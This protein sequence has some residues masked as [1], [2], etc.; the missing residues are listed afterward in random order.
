[1]SGKKLAI[2][3]L[4]SSVVALQ[5]PKYLTF[6]LSKYIKISRVCTRAQFGLSAS[7]HHHSQNRDSLK[8][9][10]GASAGLLSDGTREY[11]FID[12]A[13]TSALADCSKLR[14]IHLWRILEHKA[15]QRCSTA[16]RVSLNCARMS[17]SKSFVS[18]NPPRVL[19]ANYFFRPSNQLRDSERTCQRCGWQHPF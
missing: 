9:K 18:S 6:I 19:M 1:M 13:R 7:S 16:A 3:H 4:Q 12:S 2:Y 11:Q 14:S 10:R 15:L 5:Q 17:A 8:L